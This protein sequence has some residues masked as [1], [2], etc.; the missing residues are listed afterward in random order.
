M[1]SV[2]TEM[3]IKT[4]YKKRRLGWEGRSRARALREREERERERWVSSVRV[5]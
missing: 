4:V 2:M 1:V 3:I 5:A